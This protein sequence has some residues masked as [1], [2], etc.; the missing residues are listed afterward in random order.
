[1][2]EGTTTVSLVFQPFELTHDALALLY[3]LLAG[4]QL[5]SR[6]PLAA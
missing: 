4:A 1:V 6:D 2:G 5:K 3:F